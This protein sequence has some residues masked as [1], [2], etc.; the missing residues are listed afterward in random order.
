MSRTKNALSHRG[1]TQGANEHGEA[2]AS[3]VATKR[4]RVLQALIEGRRLH[5]FMAERLLSDHVLPSTVSEI[6]SRYGIRVER[7]RITVPGYRGLPAHVSEYWLSDAERRRAR[8]ILG[9]EVRRG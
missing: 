7:R 2:L 6:Q 5:R 8:A 4:A 9:Q 3:K 1:A